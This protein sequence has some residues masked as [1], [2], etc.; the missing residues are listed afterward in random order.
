MR[1]LI[2]RWLF[3]L[4]LAGLGA[5]PALAQLQPVP[6]FQWVW[7]APGY[8]ISRSHSAVASDPQGHFYVAGHYNPQGRNL[9]ANFRL[10]VPDLCGRDSLNA[11]VAC[12]DSSGNVL[13][14]T[15]WQGNWVEIKQLTVA[16][17]GAVYCLGTLPLDRVRVGGTLQ[18]LPYAGVPAYYRDDF[19]A[20]LSATGQPQWLRRIEGDAQ[21]DRATMQVDAA[22]RVV[23]MGHMIT[24]RAPTDLH[25]DSAY[26]I[27]T[28]PSSA[29]WQWSCYLAS[30]DAVG[31]CQWAHLLEN[32]R[33][34]TL[35]A[36]SRNG[37]VS[38][39]GT[40]DQATLLDGQPL[41]P[42]G[43]NISSFGGFMAAFHST[44]GMP[45]GAYQISTGNAPPRT[46]DR[47][48]ALPDGD[49]LLSGRQIDSLVLDEFGHIPWWAFGPMVLT[50]YA[51][52]GQARWSRPLPSFD[53][54]TLDAAGT[55]YVGVGGYVVGGAPDTLLP[56]GAM[57]DFRRCNAA[58]VALD[59]ATG[60]FRWVR[61]FGSVHSCDHVAGLASVPGGLLVLSDVDNSINIP[62]T[63]RFPPL[64]AADVFPDATPRLSYLLAKL[65]IANNTLLPAPPPRPTGGWPNPVVAGQPIQLDTTTST[66]F[67]LTDALGRLVR[68]VSV[69]ATQLPT[70]GL[71][72]GLYLLRG[73]AQAQRM[74]ITR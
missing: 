29:L 59:G 45:L 50:R 60:A 38:V 64:V 49:Y 74:M 42:T 57:G 67:S 56:A 32:E 20:R 72:P 35:A 16:P 46:A 66:A 39:T 51:P 13:W 25:L 69:G 33:S 12:Y 11:Y 27:R 17:D 31:R 55:I 6:S 44:S 21:L 1:H 24:R 22:G 36:T 48:F 47:I 71:A 14:A 30:Y 62:D 41:F 73:G 63:V 37:Q 53:A 68:A 19:V 9:S 4:L 10:P 52:D 26:V 3:G 28:S 61:P 8:F 5:T 7:S 70:E 54:L 15:A 65:H 40:G 23:V 58:I 2:F 43:S 34:F 18:S